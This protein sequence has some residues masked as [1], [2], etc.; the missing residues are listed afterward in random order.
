MYLS[1]SKLKPW[2]KDNYLDVEFNITLM[3]T[4]N[5]EK[6]DKHARARATVEQA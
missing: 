5:D 3:A 2:V 6:Q 1:Q 4:K